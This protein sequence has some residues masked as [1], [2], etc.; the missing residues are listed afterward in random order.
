M[1]QSSLFLTQNALKR[2]GC[3]G[4]VFVHL[5]PLR[6]ILKLWACSLVAAQWFCAYRLDSLLN[7]WVQ[8]PHWVARTWHRE[9]HETSSSSETLGVLI[10]FFQILILSLALERSE[11]HRKKPRR[12]RFCLGEERCMLGPGYYFLHVKEMLRDK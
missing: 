5:K 8:S 2:V 7:T 1:A 3:L 6:I 11:H 9:S 10:G 12:Y 4:Q